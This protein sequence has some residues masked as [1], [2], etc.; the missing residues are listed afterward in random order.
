MNAEDVIRDCSA[1]G[2][3]LSVGLTVDWHHGE[4]PEDLIRTL[5]EHKPEIVCALMGID[6]NSSD[7]NPEE[8]TAEFRERN[9]DWRGCWLLG[10]GFL[11]RRLV[12]ASDSHIKS[13][14]ESLIH[15]TPR[16]KADH[17]AFEQRAGDLLDQ[18]RSKGRLPPV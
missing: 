9:P 4:P 3:T 14:L 6:L 5:R 12:H 13:Q 16:T 8:F 7:T 17:L 15:E 11:A 2:V 1:R 18:L 10:L